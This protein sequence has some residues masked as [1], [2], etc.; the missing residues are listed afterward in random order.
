MQAVRWS[1]PKDPLY[2]GC[3]TIDF[4]AIAPLKE[5]NPTRERLLIIVTWYAYLMQV[6]RFVL[7]VGG[8]F[9][10]VVANSEE[11]IARSIVSA[12]ELAS[13]YSMSHNDGWTN[14]VLQFRDTYRGT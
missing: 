9:R 5:L 14:A 10:R 13:S 7:S 1:F 11:P 6:G 4:E 2:L 8:K 12:I 3:D